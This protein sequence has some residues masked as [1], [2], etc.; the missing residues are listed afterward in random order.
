[1]AHNPKRES[2]QRSRQTKQG[3]VEGAGTTFGEIVVGSPPVVL[4]S[5]GDARGS[6]LGA[7]DI[8]C[9][10]LA[11]G[12]VFP[13]VVLS[14]NSAVRGSLIEVAV[15]ERGSNLFTGLAV[16]LREV[17]FVAHAA[18]LIRQVVK[19]ILN[20]VGDSGAG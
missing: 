5:A 19:A 9:L 12:C 8:G 11:S 4:G 18:I 3:R 17:T 2:D 10:L 7:A 14:T 13:F 16:A 6:R 20:F 1:M 15:C